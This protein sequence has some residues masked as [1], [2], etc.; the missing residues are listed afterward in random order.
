MAQ[1][2]WFNPR[3][4]SLSAKRRPKSS[5][6]AKRQLGQPPAEP[7]ADWVVLDRANRQARS[8]GDRHCGDFAMARTIGG[9]FA[10][11]SRVIQALPDQ[12]AYSPA[13]V[14]EIVANILLFQRSQ[15]RLAKGLRYA[16]DSDARAERGDSQ[17]TH[18]RNRHVVRQPQHPFAGGLPGPGLCVGRRRALARRVPARV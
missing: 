8:A 2:R 6:G 13:Q 9:R 10:I 11:T 15:W 3:T 1:Q 14:E 17:A 16:G 7:D 12:A 5:G 4:A 18:D